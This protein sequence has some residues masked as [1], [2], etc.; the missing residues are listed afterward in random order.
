MNVKRCSNIVLNIS[1]LNSWHDSWHEV[2]EINV[3][4][5][6]QIYIISNSSYRSGFGKREETTEV[7]EIQK[8]PQLNP[9]LLCED[10]YNYLLEMPFPEDEDL[11]NL[12]SSVI[13]K[14]N[15]V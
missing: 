8:H 13:N 3:V 5:G 7:I 12:I 2:N 10:V 1:L 15:K 11:I 9:C 6:K 14:Y 4:F